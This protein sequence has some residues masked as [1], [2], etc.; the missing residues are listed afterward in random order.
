MLLLSCYWLVIVV[1]Y[2]MV[3]VPNYNSLLSE[4]T[5][6]LILTS[7]WICRLLRKYCKRY[8]KR[9]RTCKRAQ[10]LHELATQDS[11]T[12]F[13][14]YDGR[15]YSISFNGSIFEAECPLDIRFWELTSLNCK[16]LGYLVSGT[17]KRSV[18]HSYADFDITREYLRYVI[19]DLGLL[20]IMF[21][22]TN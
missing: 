21:S 3:H 11:G 20:P 18:R 4:G 13:E 16:N 9:H 22:E 10:F 15:V 5:L 17:F 6:V 14:T 7:C 12:F 1:V 8:H 2:G 19:N